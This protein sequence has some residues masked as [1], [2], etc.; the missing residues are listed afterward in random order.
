MP[1]NFK[2]FVSIV[3]GTNR[4]LSCEI[5]SDTSLKT[6]PIWR[7]DYPPYLP[8]EYSVNNS[9]YS[10]SSNKTYVWSNLTLIDVARGYYEGNYTLTA[11][12][13]CSNTS[14]YVNVNIIGESPIPAYPC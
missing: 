8:A 1:L 14:V 9:S 12:N 2:Y 10:L 4:T 11:E 7:R 6:D 13:D 5:H 3:N